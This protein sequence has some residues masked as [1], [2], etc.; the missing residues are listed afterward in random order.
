MARK[1][2]WSFHELSSLTST[3][4]SWSSDMVDPF[5]PESVS[6][7][8]DSRIYSIAGAGYAMRANWRK[9]KPWVFIIHHNNEYWELM[10]FRTRNLIEDAVWEIRR[11]LNEKFREDFLTSEHK[12]IAR[13][14]SLMA[15]NDFQEYIKELKDWDKNKRVRGAG[16]TRKHVPQPVYRVKF[17]GKPDENGFTKHR[18]EWLEVDDMFVQNN[19][20]TGCES[21]HCVVTRIEKHNDEYNRLYYYMPINDVE[22]DIYISS[23]RTYIC[24]KYVG[25]LG[26]SKKFMKKITSPLAV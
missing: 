16:G 5:D 1:G 19:Q 23:R 9:G 17:D 11:E 10:C 25:Q 26:K 4:M 14:A 12:S 3:E 7:T 15:R 20:D 13:R 22:N 18:M 6:K 8:C 24:S 21:N 2:K